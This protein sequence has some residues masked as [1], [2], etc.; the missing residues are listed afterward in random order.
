[1]TDVPRECRRFR[2]LLR[3][4]ELDT[5]KPSAQAR[6]E[7]HVAACEEC[8][9]A[10]VAQREALATLGRLR[11]VEPSRD[12]TAA[13]MGKVR[14]AEEEPVRLPAFLAPALVYQYVILVAFIGILASV[15]LP[16]LSRA[17]EAAGRASSA[18]NLKQLSLVFKMYANEN[19][20]QYPPLTQYKD[21][22][23]VDL[24]RLYPEYMTDL[25][26]LVRPD[27]PDTGELVDRLAQLVGES[28]IDW[29]EVTRIA[30]ISYTYSNWMIREDSEVEDLKKGYMQLARAD[31]DDDFLSGDRTFY[32]LREGIERFFITDINNPAASAMTQSEIPIMF[33]TVR[34]ERPARSQ[35]RTHGYNVLYMDGHVEFLNYGEQ[36]PATGAVADAFP[37]PQ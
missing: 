19:D 9:A 5:L 3:Q 11:P 4:Y 15:L 29:E 1:M 36:F 18:N 34:K 7:Q 26:V 16:A 8:S 23:M 21:V 30:A 13:V 20:G 2:R 14:R 12:L 28:P 33:E 24:E 17:R 6:V 22:W 27:L 32:H 31:L 35:R 37:P 10:L 25:T